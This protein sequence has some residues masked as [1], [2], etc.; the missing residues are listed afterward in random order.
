MVDTVGEWLAAD[1]VLP[2]AAAL[3]DTDDT[4]DLRAE[5]ADVDAK[6]ATVAEQWAAGDI[7]DIERAAARRVLDER[8]QAITSLLS[9]V[10]PPMP[11]L[12]VDDLRAAWIG[13]SFAARQ[14]VVE[15][16]CRPAITVASAH[17]D[18]R[19]LSTAERVDLHLP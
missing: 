11:V 17:R 14:A 2:V 16:L 19:R 10:S 7:T 18:G 5:L 8:R 13:G 3:G 4:V 1:L 9:R 6:M 15:S 12:T